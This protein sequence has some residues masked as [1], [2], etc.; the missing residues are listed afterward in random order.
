MN[1]KKHIPSQMNLEDTKYAVIGTIPKERL[2]IIKLASVLLTQTFKMSK[3]K[4]SRLCD[5][6]GRRLLSVDS[7]NSSL[8]AHT[9]R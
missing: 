5:I 3:R 6:P 1:E 4:Q 8:L 2:K 7:A 9:V